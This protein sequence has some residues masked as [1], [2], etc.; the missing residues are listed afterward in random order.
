VAYNF[1]KP[2][3]EDSCPCGVAFPQCRYIKGLSNVLVPA[4]T[5]WSNL[6]SQGCSPWDF[7]VVV[8]VLAKN[9]G[10]KDHTFPPKPIMIWSSGFKLDPWEGVSLSARGGLS[11]LSL[12]SR[13]LRFAG[14]SCRCSV[15]FSWRRCFLG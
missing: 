10:W 7:G 11:S 15:F 2:W 5:E 3:L 9:K 6:G 8:F 14:D 1:S 12:L 13:P 4:A